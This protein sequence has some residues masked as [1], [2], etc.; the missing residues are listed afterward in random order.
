[1]S[2]GGSL[3]Q[4]GMDDF[5]ALPTGGKI[6]VVCIPVAVAFFAYRA[7]LKAAA[8]PSV[9]AT[10]A[11]SDGIATDTNQS[12]GPT[13]TGQ[14]ATPG[15]QGPAGPTGATGPTGAP[16]KTTTAPVV[17]SKPPVKTAPKPAPKPAMQTYTVQNGDSLSAIAS[18]LGL[19]GGWQALY[20]QNKPLIDTTAQ[21]QHGVYKNDQ[22]FIYAGEK[23]NITGLK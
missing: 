6:A 15:P 2:E 9:D 19:K 16:G 22:N 20:A 23:L 11:A 12:S 10:T 21:K 13:S 14:V 18:K 4:K 3:I 1:M 7:K 8:A 17:V 5:K